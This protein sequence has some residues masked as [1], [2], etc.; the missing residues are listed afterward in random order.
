MLIPYSLNLISSTNVTLS[1]FSFFLFLFSL[2]LFFLY[3]LPACDPP[4]QVLGAPRG[5]VGYPHYNLLLGDGGNQQGSLEAPAWRT[6]GR[7][8]EAGRGGSGGA[9]HYGPDSCKW[10][11]RAPAGYTLNVTVLH[12]DTRPQD[13][14]KVSWGTRGQGRGWSGNWNVESF[15]AEFH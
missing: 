9:V 13:P 7:Q 8:E 1:F 2:I 12:L 6:E 4:V 5:L 10:V 11:M 15:K 3:F 14:I